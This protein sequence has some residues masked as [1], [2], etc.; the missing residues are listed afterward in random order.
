MNKQ[1]IKTNL[2]GTAA[3]VTYYGGTIGAGV[4]F[5]SLLNDRNPAAIAVLVVF[6]LTVEGV[7]RTLLDEVLA[8]VTPDEDSDATATV[9]L[10]KTEEAAR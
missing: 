2:I 4:G 10:V 3:N 6:V 7:L 5:Y 1:R 8:A 9:S